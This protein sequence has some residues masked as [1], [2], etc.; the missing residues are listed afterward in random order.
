MRTRLRCVTFA[1]VT[2]IVLGTA[3]TARA[4]SL[5]A[6]IDKLSTAVEPELIEWR[7][8]LHQNPELSNRE[9]E[10]AKYVA[11]R[12]RSFGLEPQ[13]GVAKTGVV[14]LLKGGRPG[15]LVA[16]RADM[17]A[18]PVREEANVP[19]ASKAMGEYEG[20]KVGV[21]HACGHD[22]HV[23]IL[24]ATAR[25][26]SQ[27]KER[28]P[29]S[30][31]FLFQPAE[32]GAPPEEEPAGAQQMVKEGVMQNVDA[33]F[34]LHVFANVPT[35]TIT[36]RSGPFMAAADRFE[37]IVKG[38]QTHGSAPWRGV[39]PIVVGAQIVT[40]LQTIVSRNVDITK[41][42]A[43]VSV[44][45]FQSGVRNN[46]I[47]DSARLVGTIRTFDDD[48]QSDIHARITRIAE[49]VASG[50]GA[51]VDVKIVRGYPVTSNDPKLTAKMLPTLERVA[52]G[53]VK[54]SELITGAEDFTFFQRQAPGMFVFLGITPLEQVG[55]AA[56]NHSPLFYVDEKALPTGVRALANLAL[57]Y[58]MSAAKRN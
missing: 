48:V 12:L 30:V 26:L 46:I 6:E 52:P 7:R 33:V 45:Q 18:L 10:T 13:T 20:N 32:E 21:M 36:Y 38:K 9:V 22:T 50:A 54:E 17:D 37:I 35:G 5:A 51:T 57:D 34:G 41:L 11:E 23:A 39:D 27:M 28:L 44:G 15:P 56:A 19:F 3:P 14:A 4:Q 58:M 47:P 29:G 16:L 24:L 1:A 8:H 25:V 2:A 53:K 55:K 49:G 42:P 43:I 40:A 31:K